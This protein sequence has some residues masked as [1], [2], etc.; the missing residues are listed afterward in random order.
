MYQ[1]LIVEDELFSM[2]ALQCSIETI[3]P[4]EFQILIS[5]N[6]LDALNLCQ[7]QKPDIILVDLN[8]PGISGLSLIQTL[9][10]Y[11]F[12]GKV[13]IITAHD[14]SKYIR[15]ALS[16]GVVSYLL[17]PV[18]LAQLQDAV[19]KCLCLLQEQEASK[20][21]PLDSL[22]SYA[23]NYLIRDILNCHAPQK[24]LEDVYGWKTDGNLSVGMLYWRPESKTTS[25]MR[26]AYLQYM[27]SLFGNYFLM[28]SAVI[29]NHIVIFLHTAKSVES[30]QVPLILS[31]CMSMIRRKFFNGSF[32][33]TEFVQTYSE[34]Y[35]AVKKGLFLAEHTE[36]IFLNQNPHPAKVWSLDDRLRL[37]QK[38]VQRLSQK[39]TSQLVQ[40]LKRKLES[41][42][43]FFAWTALFLEALELCDATADLYEILTIFQS[44]NWTVLLENWL[45]SFYSSGDTDH[46]PDQTSQSERAVSMIEQCFA[47]DLS[48]EKVATQL[49]LTPTYFSS[50]FKKE[51]GKS[52]PHYLAEFRIQHAVRLISEGERNINQIAKLC[53]FQNKKYFLEM[54]KKYSGYPITQFIQN[55]DERTEDTDL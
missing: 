16:L 33:L 10:D 53:G 51:T 6:G 18:S 4:E 39:Q 32:I 35:G 23:Q 46:F 36:H 30:A 43:N 34:L 15:E 5:D 8:I 42:D 24:I 54:F 52:F 25:Q 26:E 22:F 28:L 49:G 38:F 20:K 29:E 11:H 44:K 2:Q 12:A 19:D 17:K 14:R 9:N 45:E 55:T 3:Y 13:V 47:S 50:L 21:N 31:V 37:R 1:I 41:G 7:C 48:Q 40:Y 27:T